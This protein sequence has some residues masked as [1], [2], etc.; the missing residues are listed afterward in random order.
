MRIVVASGKGGTGKTTVATSLAQ[1]AAERDAVRF[2]DCDVE[3]PNAALFL[4]P[5]LETHR[6]VGIRV[7]RVDAQACT[8]C[9]RC[10]EICQFHAIAVVGKKVLV[11]DDLCHGCGSCTWNCPEQAI[12]EHLAVTGAIDSGTTPE[13]ITFAQGMMNVGQTMGVPILRELK[14]WTPATRDVPPS[15]SLRTGPSTSLRASGALEIRDAPPGA[16]CPVVETMRGADFALLVTEPTPFGLH[17]LKQVAA[18]AH[19]LGIPAGVVVNRD[20][21]GDDAVGTWCADSGL[22]ILLRIPM[23]RRIAVAI[24]SGRTLVDA[25]PDYRPGFHDLLERIVAGVNP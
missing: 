25:A 17:D 14:K 3:A 22:P 20:G 11:F 12:S 1:V 13:G 9:G 7:P 6:D 10:A 5:D 19:D 8:F 2:L 23:E 18:I 16:S 15:T 24:A 21:I 4:H